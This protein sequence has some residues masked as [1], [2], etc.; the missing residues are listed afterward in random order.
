MVHRDRNAGNDG[1]GA[2]VGVAQSIDQ[3]AET[4]RNAAC[5]DGNVKDAKAA[6]D[7]ILAD[8]DQTASVEQTASRPSRRLREDLQQPASGRVRVPR[9]SG[10][11]LM[12]TKP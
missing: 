10:C 5:D 12:L 3:D 9:S 11:G 1:G 8:R 6:L 2:V 7:R 4:M